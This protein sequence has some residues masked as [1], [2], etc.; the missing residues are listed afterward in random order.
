MQTFAAPWSPML[1]VSTTLLLVLFLGVAWF[2]GAVGAALVLG[3][4]A[5]AFAYSVRGYSVG[6]GE[7][8]VHR[9]GWVRRIDLSRLAGVEV[10]PERLSRSLRVGGIGGLFSSVGFFWSPSLGRYRA[11][12]TDA[13]RAVILDLG[14]ETVLV[15]PD[16]PEELAAAVRL[17]RFY[18][19]P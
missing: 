15:T 16:D 7:L 3:I 13:R 9:P 17:Q 11:Y 2:A 4:T 14:E 6:R 8:I 12:A 1:K 10:G 5:L 18:E 19:G